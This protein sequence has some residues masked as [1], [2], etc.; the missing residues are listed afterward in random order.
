MT[1]TGLCRKMHHALESFLTKQSACG[2]RVGNVQP[3][4][5]KSGMPMNPA[6]L[7]TGTFIVRERCAR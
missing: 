1:H 7:V 6:A 3:D 5:A 4:E 2:I